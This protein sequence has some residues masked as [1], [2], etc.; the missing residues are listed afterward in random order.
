MTFSYAR[1][2][3]FGTPGMLGQTFG[4]PTI[5]LSPFTNV[6][7]C[8]YIIC[9][10]EERENKFPTTSKPYVTFSVDHRNSIAIYHTSICRYAYTCLCER[11]YTCMPRSC[12]SIWT[13][14]LIFY[15]RCGSPKQKKGIYLQTIVQLWFSVTNYSKRSERDR[16]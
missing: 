13:R 7:L 14:I 16:K 1:Y 6:S 12:H 8:F 10:Q 11:V 4:S 3:I 5:D 15:A 9:T 2:F